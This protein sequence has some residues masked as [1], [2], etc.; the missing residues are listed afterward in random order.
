MWCEI[1]Q[2]WFLSLFT[3]VKIRF[4]MMERCLVMI[5]AKPIFSIYIPRSEIKIFW[6]RIKTFRQRIFYQPSNLSKNSGNTS[7]NNTN[8]NLIIHKYLEMGGWLE[9]IT[10]SASTMFFR[11]LLLKIDRKK[12]KI[13]LWLGIIF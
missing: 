4:R 10:M 11:C 5:K 12:G 8:P 2:N 1:F 7:W 9:E 3:E 6:L 13:H